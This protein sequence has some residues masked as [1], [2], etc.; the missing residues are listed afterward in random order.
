MT[1]AR[2][3]LG[4]PG[5]YPVPPTSVPRL[6]GERLDVAAFVGVT[7]RGP[8]NVPLLDARGLIEPPPPG[9]ALARQRSVAQRITSWTEFVHLYGGLRGPGRLPWAVRSY[10]EQGGEVAWI[11]RITAPVQ[12]DADGHPEGIG[13]A[14]LPHLCFAGAPLCLLAR[15]E[16]A[17]SCALRVSLGFTLAPQPFARAEVA[18]LSFALDDPPPPGSLLRASFDPPGSGAAL[19][20]V[21]GLVVDRT[22]GLV[23]ASLSAP[24]PGKPVQLEL[25]TAALW[26]DDGEGREESYEAL[27]LSSL[28]PRW[29]ATVLTRESNL[30]Y[31]DPRWIEATTIE[32]DPRLPRLARRE[33]VWFCGGDDRY[34]D[35]EVE[36]FF[37]AGWDR[38]TQPPGDGIAALA[39][40]P[41]V[42]SVVVPD[43]YHPQALHVDEDV[44][45]VIDVGL[46]RP[47]WTT[48]VE[49]EPVEV[50]D[51]DAIVDALPGLIRDVGSQL[52]A[53]VASQLAVVEIAE[54]LRMVALLD[55][56]PGLSLQQ[57]LAWRQRFSSSWAAAYHPWLRLAPTSNEPAREVPL[58]IG[59]AAVAA[60]IIAR[61]EI[62]E[63]VPYGPAN[64]L[65][66]GVIDVEDRVSPQRHA[67]LHPRGINVFLRERDGVRLTAARTLS[68]D[69]QF[70]Q[71][72]VRR[73]FQLLVRTLRRQL[74][75]VVFE[76]HDERLRLQLR[77]HLRLFLRELHRAGA[78]RGADEQDAFFV[79]CDASNNP[80]AI[81]DR[82]MLIAEVGVAPAEP[83][84]FILLAIRREGDQLE[85][86]E[87]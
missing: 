49:L 65:A 18:G 22:A 19:R 20:F 62:D 15:N 50:P 10:F 59:P 86:T 52:E 75:W 79:R 28:H 23:H 57:M 4:A 29:L 1:I 56:P 34:A 26:L 80:P 27:G 71:L 36:H 78:F 72:S 48:C 11:V 55:V 54:Q 87:R 51:P 69:P 61:R 31:P 46:G 6:V 41:E 12:L 16:G 9:L 24:W 3:E 33:G 30:A 84:E 47:D 2:M 66:L 17:W 82:G 81:V 68:G 64:V 76:P 7:S 14:P 13:R 44:R 53:I 60:G 25:V 45:D 67:E 70:R 40:A 21:T 39:V 77:E 85:V 35:I 43:L 58:R 32:V 37:D 42:A 38:R 63:G 5:V 74:Q 73:L 83:V 8:A